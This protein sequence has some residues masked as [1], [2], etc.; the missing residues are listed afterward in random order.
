MDSA[1]GSLELLPSEVGI[2]AGGQGGER[3]GRSDLVFGHLI[4]EMMITYPGGNVM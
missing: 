4:I 3:W 1:T 2:Y